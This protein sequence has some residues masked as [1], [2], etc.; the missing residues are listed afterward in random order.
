M[1]RL[2]VRRIAVNGRRGRGVYAKDVILDIIRRLGVKGGAGF[3]YEYAGD[4]IGRM[5][6]DER[7]T[8]CNMSIEGGARPG[9]VNPDETTFAY[10]PGRRFVPQGA[11]SDR[12]PHS[13]PCIPPPPPPPHTTHTALP[14]P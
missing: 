5:S 8:I 3:A 10:L 4:T 13:S 14:P 9:D 11:A 1:D 6:M 7:M 12:P 2:K